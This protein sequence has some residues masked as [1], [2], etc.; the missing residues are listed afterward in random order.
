MGK[1]FK[2]YRMFILCLIIFMVF[3]GIGIFSFLNHKQIQMIGA[4]MLALIALFLLL[5]RYK[6]VLYGDMMMI[7]EWKVAAML[8][9]LIEYKDIQ[10][11]EKKSKHHLVI[12][13]QRV[14]HVYVFDSDLFL[15]TYHSLKKNK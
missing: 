15:S 3:L 13:H 7:Y 9:T 11:I 2:E 10:S 1:K 6:M 14:S 12:T 8:P 5:L 4:M